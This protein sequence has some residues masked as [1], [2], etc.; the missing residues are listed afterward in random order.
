MLKSQSTNTL[1]IDFNKA[2]CIILSLSCTLSIFRCAITIRVM[3]EKEILAEKIRA[4]IN[5]GESRDLYDLCFIKQ[6]S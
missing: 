6:E 3:H 1:K 2:K 4:L 5:R